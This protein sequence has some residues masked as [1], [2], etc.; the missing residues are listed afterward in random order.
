MCTRP[1][2]TACNRCCRHALA[3]GAPLMPV[4]I[5]G[6]AQ[7]FYTLHGRV[8]DALQRLSRALR[9]SIIPFVGRS[10]LSPF[11]PLPTPLTCVV[12]RPLNLGAEPIERPSAEQVDALHAQFCSELRRIFEA[13]KSA[14]PGFAAKKLYLDPEAAA[15]E[16]VEALRERRRLEEFHVFPA[17]L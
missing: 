11:V 3:A 9:V 13:H 7:L 12:G 8:H 5:F 16:D 14:H 15:E 10:W 17:K 4:Y 1:H 2:V 6:Q